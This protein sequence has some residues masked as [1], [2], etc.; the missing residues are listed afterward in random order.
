M[1]RAVTR[2]TVARRT[3][4]VPRSTVTELVV[5]RSTMARSTKLQAAVHPPAVAR[6][7]ELRVAVNP[8]AVACLTAEKPGRLRAPRQ[9]ETAWAAWR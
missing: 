6:S 4:A 3:T 5:A 1:S 8:R 2:S 9:T 7:M